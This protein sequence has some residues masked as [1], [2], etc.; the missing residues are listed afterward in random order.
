MSLAR[1]V[2]RRGLGAEKEGAR[3]DRQ[4]SGSSTIRLYSDQNVQR[5]Q[6]LTLVFVQTLGLR[7]EAGYPGRWR[8]PDDGPASAPRSLLV[9]MLDVRELLKEGGIVRKRHQ[10]DQALGI[11]DASSSPMA[12]QISSVRRGLALHQP[13]A[14]R[15]AVGDGD[16]LLWLAWCSNRGRSDFFRISACSWRNAVDANRQTRTQRL[17]MCT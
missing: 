2:A 6:Q 12:S 10:I 16:E 3:R 14:V 11:L 15:D 9:L 8:C 1:I 4:R 7:V 13:A 17:A 5:I